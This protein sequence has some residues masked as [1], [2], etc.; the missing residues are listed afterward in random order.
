MNSKVSIDFSTHK[1]PDKALY[2]VAMNI[3]AC[4]LSVG[5]FASLAELAAEVKE[6]ATVFGNYLTKMEQGNRLVTAEKNDAREGLIVKLKS[7]ALKVQ[8][9]S[10]GSEAVILS[11]GFDV[12]KKPSPVGMLEQ[13]DNVKVKPGQMSGSLEVSWNV[14]P[15]AATYEIRVMKTPKGNGNVFTTYTT[16]KR[17]ILLENLELR[18]SYLVQIAGVGANPKRVWSV[19]VVSGFVS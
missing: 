12:H 8:D 10:G 6:L 11:S 19:E 16:T 5:V 14:V 17:R 9:I 13:P 4:I 18:E 1:Y 3:V 7:L 2:V 15:N